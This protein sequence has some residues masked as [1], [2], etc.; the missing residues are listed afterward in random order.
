MGKEQE[1]VPSTG[2]NTL[3][4]Q[5]HDGDADAFG[6][7]MRRYRKRD[8]FLYFQIIN[9]QWLTEDIIQEALV[10]AFWGMPHL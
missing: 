10:R 9:D 6:E 8:L 1:N 5:S 3:I 2:E 4:Q 7:L